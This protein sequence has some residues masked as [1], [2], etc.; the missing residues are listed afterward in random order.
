MN[1]RLS[2]IIFSA[3]ALSL[4]VNAQPL[5]TDFSQMNNSRKFF[6]KGNEQI[7]RE[8]KRMQDGELLKIKLPDG[9]SLSPNSDNDFIIYTETNL[10]SDSEAGSYSSEQN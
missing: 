1:I 8:I 6:D 3:I 2:V 10:E 5:I 4:P 9:W 7:E